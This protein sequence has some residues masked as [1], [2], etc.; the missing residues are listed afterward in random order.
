M[1][2]EVVGLVS[3]ILMLGSGNSRDIKF[4]SLGPLKRI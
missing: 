2:P 3:I 4:D 1:V